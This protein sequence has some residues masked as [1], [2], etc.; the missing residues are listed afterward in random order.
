MRRKIRNIGIAVLAI[1]VICLVIGF[2]PVEKTTV[3]SS[4]STT[5]IQRMKVFE[6]TITPSKIYVI[7]G[8][9]HASASID[10]A[11]MTEGQYFAWGRV[12]HPNQGMNLQLGV[13]GGSF[14]FTA[15]EGTK[16]YIVFVNF[17]S[18]SISL[19]TTDITGKYST[20]SSPVLGGLGVIGFI[21]GAVVA[22]A[23][24][25][26]TPPV[27]E[28]IPPPQPQPVGSAFCPTCG[29]PLSYVP[30]KQE[31]YCPRCKTSKAMS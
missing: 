13:Y 6:K 19:S 3:L 7:E 21:I 29:T 27:P 18:Y 16:Y 22:I 12:G 4:A 23:G 30:E 10:F 31:W 20:A 25:I 1:S 2:I 8:S 28:T 5:T 26:M 15:Q 14:S 24:Y 9:F 11:V 17:H